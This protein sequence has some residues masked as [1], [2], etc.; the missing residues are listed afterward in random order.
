M[1]NRGAGLWRKVRGNEVIPSHLGTLIN[2]SET[3]EELFPYLFKCLVADI[4]TKIVIS[5]EIKLFQIQC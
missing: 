1:V 3:K 5:N 2:C 4:T